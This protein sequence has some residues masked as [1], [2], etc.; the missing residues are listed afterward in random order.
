M[1]D[2]ECI[3]CILIMNG[4]CPVVYQ[5]AGMICLGSEVRENVVE[6]VKVIAIKLN[7][8]LLE[9]GNLFRGKTSMYGYD[10]LF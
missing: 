4:A 10:P 6:R 2:A 5:S 3:T 7:T 8:Q 1:A 9:Q